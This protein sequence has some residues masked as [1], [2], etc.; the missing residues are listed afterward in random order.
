[1][2]R[3]DF[4]IKFEIEPIVKLRCFAKA[5]K[6]NHR[7]YC[8]LKHITIGDNAVCK[9][10]HRV[11]TDEDGYKLPYCDECGEQYQL[12]RPGKTQCPNCG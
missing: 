12:V 9:E 2:A 6:F 5:C 7:F 3:N 1:M 8:N 10:Y 11:N 4:V